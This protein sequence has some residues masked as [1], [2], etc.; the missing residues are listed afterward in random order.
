MLTSI[1]QI[2]FITTLVG[3]FVVVNYIFSV[4]TLVHH[5]MHVSKDP[6]KV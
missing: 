2:A 3:G 4:L 1:M 6:P 5:S